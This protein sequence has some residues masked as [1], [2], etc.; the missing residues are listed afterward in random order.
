[1]CIRDRNPEVRETFIKR[2]KIIKGVKKY[3]DDIGFLE[4][5]TPI[6]HPILGGAAAKSISAYCSSFIV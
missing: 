6:M 3:L 2:T 4:V 5:E 1:M